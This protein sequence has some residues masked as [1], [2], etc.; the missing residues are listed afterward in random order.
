MSASSVVSLLPQRL[1]KGT[2]F[3][4][5]EQSKETDLV[6][7]LYTTIQNFVT[8]SS[9]TFENNDTLDHEDTFDS[10]SEDASEDGETDEETDAT[11]PDD[12]DDKHIL[13]YFSLDYMKKVL[14]YYA[15]VD[16]N[17]KRKHSWRS[18]SRR[19]KKIP[20]STYLT[21]FRKYIEH[22][23]NK[24]Q[25]LNSIDQYVFS[26]FEN[27][28]EKSISVHD[29][30]LKRWAR[31]KAAELS[32]DNFSASDH[33]SCSFKQRHNI[34]SRKITKL[35]TKH[36]LENETVIAKSAEQFVKHVRLQIQ[37]HMLD[38]HQIINT[39]R[40]GLHKEIHSTRTLS[41]GGEKNTFG[42]IKSKNACTHSYTLQPSINIAGEVVGPIFLCMQES[43]GKM[44]DSVKKKTFQA[45][46]VI[47]S[48][49]QS[50]KLSSTHIP[51]WIENALLPY[52]PKNFLLLSDAWAGSRQDIIYKNYPSVTRLQIPQRTTDKIQPFD[53]FYNRQMKSLFRLAYDRVILDQLPISM[54]ERNNIIKLVS[55]CHSQMTADIFHGLIKTSHV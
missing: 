24:Q 23:G 22:N 11:F 3:Q 5:N 26:L 35:V 42:L 4:Y 2:D 39:D 15:E 27:A 38:P 34:V 36:T 50:G 41:F 25:K 13:N 28:R 32:L 19:F 47:L 54:A 52:A 37:S 20:D 48:C 33:R 14:D 43:G 51:Y 16:E 55:L 29:I 6:E 7:H 21:R 30:D 49:S 1:L 40:V 8:C 9:Y 17:G 18:I 12:Q 44:S 31:Q 45:T 10:L 53:M 46:N